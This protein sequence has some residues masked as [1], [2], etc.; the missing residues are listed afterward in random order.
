MAV[1]VCMLLLG[2]FIAALV[3]ARLDSAAQARRMI[4]H[5]YEVLFE[6]DNLYAQIVSAES[7]QRGYVA[8][9]QQSFLDEY[10]EMLQSKNFDANTIET[11]LQHLDRLTADN[12]V[13]QARLKK[14]HKSV[15]DKKAYME[16]SV[17]MVAEKS[18]QHAQD[19]IALNRGQELMSDIRAQL[20][21]MKAHEI[22]LLDDRVKQYDRV[23]A[24]NI[25]TTLSIVVLLVGL[26]AASLLSMQ[27]EFTRRKAVEE[28]LRHHVG[29]QKAVLDSSVYGLV[30]SDEKGHIT[31]V[32]PA[33][34]KLLGYTAAEMM[35][36]LA[37]NLFHDPD[38]LAAR[39]KELSQDLG[40]TVSEDLG[41]FTA[42]P[43]IKD[44]EER[45]WT[46]ITKDG[47]RVP[48][49]ASVTVL[50]DSAGHT[51]GYVGV[52]Q[53]ITERRQ[54]EMMKN[55]FI[56]T[57][58]HELRT[59]LTSIRGSLGLI[60]GSMSHEL[61][62]QVRS[63]ITIAHKNS[64]RLVR[65]INNILDI[66]KIE[67]GH[68]VYDR[69]PV[70]VGPLLRQAME[71]A[72][73]MA[74][75]HKVALRLDSAID[76]AVVVG[77]Y[78]RLLQ[79]LANLL[80]NAIKFS[81]S[82]GTVVLSGVKEAGGKL[83]LSVTDNGP[84][85]P[86]EFR[87]RIFSKFAQAD[88]SMSRQKS[89]SGLGL[90]ISK[91]IAESMDGF[92]DYESVPGRTVFA[93]HLP[94]ASHDSHDYLG[95]DEGKPRI[96]VCEDDG[97]IASLLRLILQK[98]GFDCDVAGSIQA[99]RDLLQSRTFAAMTLDLNLPDGNGMTLIQELKND[100]KLYS[101]PVIVITA[102]PD[103]V[104]NGLKTEAIG[105]VD[106]L[107]KPIDVSRLRRALRDLSV[108]NG[109]ARILHIEDDPDIAGFIAASMK[110]HAIITP[111]RTL[112]EARR[113][114]AETSYDLAVLDI[115][116]PDGNGLDLLPKLSASRIPVI[117]LSVHE[118]GK[119][120]Q[121]HVRAS[122]VKSVV[123]ETKIIE[124]IKSLI[125]RKE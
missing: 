82:G 50:R 123:S 55:E 78:D 4:A 112:A 68:I 59:P 18:L 86:K 102:E 105:V 26:V 119:D 48:I 45:E 57:V 13:Q 72:Q 35:G 115:A 62:E 34:E 41:V 90:S 118:T 76:N 95:K 52:V 122:L 96:L 14:L 63:L 2:G 109:I 1:I 32:N 75:D 38:E 121:E 99:A 74:S 58:S 10:N 98:E 6:I 56:S 100:E 92:L 46:Y 44:S 125:G 43:E 111:A 33:M 23:N 24:Y 113:K 7:S 107:T 47:R 16:H 39:A 84:G 17:H 28:T 88:S 31:Q 3:L 29:F 64:E 65:L 20:N 37:A 42:V 21:D 71:E 77:D 9:G 36:K 80:S 93:M 103:S 49:L 83:R 67:S 91:A 12:S 108:K 114:L 5:T 66:E 40:E 53:D 97:D 54:I 19:Y 25:L 70:I 60:S 22:G 30:I 27:R 69:K 11:R 124:T 8:T 120:I 89:G 85:V 15:Q 94:E 81:P 101:L 79:V 87:Q 51:I 110:G 61:P 116:M 117:I 73:G 104:K 106:W